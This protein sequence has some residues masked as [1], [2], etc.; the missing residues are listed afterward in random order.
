MM[1]F[2]EIGGITQ[3]VP[4][5]ARGMDRR[6]HLTTNPRIVSRDIV[7]YRAARVAAG[8]PGRPKQKPTRIV[9][10]VVTQIIVLAGHRAHAP[11]A[12]HDDHGL[13]SCAG[14]S[15]TPT[16]GSTSFAASRFAGKRRPDI[17]HAF[18]TLAATLICYSLWNHHCLVLFP[19]SKRF[20][21][22]HNGTLTFSAATRD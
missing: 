20:S 7:S 19:S 9:A 12:W 8:K 18:L 6:R 10:D 14:S 4:A 2:C 5:T 11:K 17:H 13:A 15:S 1:A 21:G 22:V 16:V 3:D